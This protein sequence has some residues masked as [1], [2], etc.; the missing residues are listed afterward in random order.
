VF[1]VD[2]FLWAKPVKGLKKK[3]PAAQAD[4]SFEDDDL[5][6]VSSSQEPSTS[7]SALMHE[8]PSSTAREDITR[9]FN[10]MLDS[11][12]PRLGRSPKLATPIRRGALTQLINLA[13][14]PEQLGD[15]AEVMKLYHD[16]DSKK[17][18]IEETDAGDAF[19]SEPSF[20]SINRL[21]TGHVLYS[22]MHI[23]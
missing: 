6:V 4:T 12:L 1:R 14:T 10:E 17:K 21:L 19:I 5:F 18:I 23:T 8:T 16:N 7:T 2:Q 15:V 11:L 20:S 9:M 13:S 22:E 3:K